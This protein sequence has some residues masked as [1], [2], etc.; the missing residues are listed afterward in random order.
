LKLTHSAYRTDLLSSGLELKALHSSLPS[1]SLSSEASKIAVKPSTESAVVPSK[2]IQS[3]IDIFVAPFPRN[4]RAMIVSTGD[5]W[6]P[7]TFGLVGGTAE[8]LWFFEAAMKNWLSLISEGLGEARAAG[9]DESREVIVRSYSAAN[10]DVEEGLEN[11]NEAGMA[12]RMNQI[13]E[14]ST[15]GRSILAHEHLTDSIY[16]TVCCVRTRRPSHPIPRHHGSRLFSSGDQTR[17]SRSHSLTVLSLTIL[18]S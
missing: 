8:L 17:T 11:D 5:K 15:S 12:E 10:E 18:Q 6:S 14:V 2:S 3:H 1:F 4:Y 13:F 7:S 9:R 16:M